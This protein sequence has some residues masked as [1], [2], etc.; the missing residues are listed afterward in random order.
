[1]LPAHD[2]TQFLQVG[3]REITVVS[4]TSLDVFVNAVQ[5]KCVKVHQ[6]LLRKKGEN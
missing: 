2:I 1:M 5:I 4:V 3:R 6:L